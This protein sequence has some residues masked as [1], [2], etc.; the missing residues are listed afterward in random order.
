L[1]L[2]RPHI[3]ALIEHRDQVV[4]AWQ[5]AHPGEDVFEDRAL[6]ITGYLPISVDSWVQALSR[7]Q[8]VRA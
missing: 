1:Q 4:A 8:G 7:A 6:E 3:Q 2:F 5:L